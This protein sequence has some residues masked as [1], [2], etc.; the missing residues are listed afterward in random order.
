MFWIGMI[1]GAAVVG[2]IVLVAMYK[3]AKSFH[4]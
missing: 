3:F 4:W 2:L 1:V